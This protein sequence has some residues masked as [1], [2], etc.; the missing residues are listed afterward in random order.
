MPTNRTKRSK[1]YKI[2]KS[3]ALLK[4]NNH[5]EEVNVNISNNNNK[6]NLKKR[7][8]EKQYIN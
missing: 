8:M 4:E 3:N 6:T 1:L 2:E 7:L 5:A